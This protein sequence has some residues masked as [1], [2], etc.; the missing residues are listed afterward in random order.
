MNLYYFGRDRSHGG[1]CW[2]PSDEELF[3][4]FTSLTLEEMKVKLKEYLD[5]ITRKTYGL[6]RF[7]FESFLKWVAEEAEIFEENDGTP[8]LQYTALYF[9]LEG[10]TYP[11]EL[12]RDYNKMFGLEWDVESSLDPSKV[13]DPDF[14]K[15]CCDR[16]SEIKKERDEKK[17][18]KQEIENRAWDLVK[19]Y[20]KERE[21]YLHLI[22]MKKK[23]KGTK[24][25]PLPKKPSFKEW[26]DSLSTPEKCLMEVMGERHKLGHEIKKIKED[27]L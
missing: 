23:L 6:T 27:V 24:K 20:T 15:H 7:E 18:I 14:W 11:P 25:I 21:E 10:K 5:S 22:E 9:E 19:K 13:L 16:F 3:M 4:L 1:S 17:K 2:E 8:Y 26:E 12:D